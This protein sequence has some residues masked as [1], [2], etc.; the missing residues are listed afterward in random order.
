[1]YCNQLQRVPSHYMVI[2]SSYCMLSQR[3][4]IL[5]QQDLHQ[6]LRFKQAEMI[7]KTNGTVSMSG[8]IDSI[9]RKSLK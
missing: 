8:V 9:L 6:K 1:M 4:T 7:K 5:I 2:Y 3:I